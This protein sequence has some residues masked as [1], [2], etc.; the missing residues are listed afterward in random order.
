MTVSVEE[1]LDEDTVIEDNSQHISCESKHELLMFCWSL[2]VFWITCCSPSLSV[3]MEGLR[4]KKLT[5]GTK[6]NNF[7]PQSN[8]EEIVDTGDVYE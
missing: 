4:S 3:E 1:D 2:P 6:N 8:E 7:I 5:D